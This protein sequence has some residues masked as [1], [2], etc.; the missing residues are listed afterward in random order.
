M[1]PYHFSSSLKIMADY[2]IG[3]IPKDT[4]EIIP[5]YLDER[6]RDK[7]LCFEQL[8]VFR[9]ITVKHENVFITG[10]AGQ[11]MHFTRYAILSLYYTENDIYIYILSGTGKSMLL[12]RII[13][14]LEQNYTELEF[15]ITAPTGMAAYTISGTTIHSFAQMGINDESPE[16]YIDRVTVNA[17][18]LKERW[19]N[20]K[21]LII[22]EIS[23]VDSH[24]F[25][26]LDII[27]RRLRGNDTP[28]G[29]IQLIVAGDFFQL[30]P[31]KGRFAFESQSWSGS[32]D[33]LI[34]L[35][36]IHRQDD[37]DFIKML[38]ELRI[39]ELT[40]QSIAYIRSL[41]RP[42]VLP[43]GVIPVHLRPTRKE[44]DSVNA[45]EL[46]KLDT[47]PFTYKAYDTGPAS[48]INSQCR[49][50]ERLELKE[51]ARVVLLK[52][53]DSMLVNGS[54]GTV[55]S[56]SKDIG[57]P[58]TIKF[59]NGITTSI[60]RDSW[61]SEGRTPVLKRSQIP[62][63]LAWALT[64][65]KCQGLTIDYAYIDAYRIFA[66]GQLYVALSRVRCPNG[67]QVVN[68]VP[69]KCKVDS[70]VKKF[71]TTFNKK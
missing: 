55:I 5:S 13:T 58:P 67:L 54:T 30:P 11:Y 17:T 20:L 64:I 53:I 22:D 63:T 31:V 71:Y 1:I 52:N 29:G 36:Y 6:K 68:F 47:E 14:W 4:L 8:K 41:S 42:L 48:V 16:R 28:W 2:S 51:G 23:M 50:Q 27:A 66:C 9:D 3:L 56:F 21:V 25:D 59:D 39:G 70:K 37:I 34:E 15:A 33:L 62:L 32:F 40:P 57:R 24:M 61:E 10:S 46:T 65:H 38:A 43:D 69:S 7:P 12:R 44:V 19:Q 18:L 49:Y 35:K 45:F 60:G 26:K